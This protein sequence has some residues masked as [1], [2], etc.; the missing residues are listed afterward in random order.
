M[1]KRPQ[2]FTLI[3]LL[4]VIAIIAILAAML[5]PV[6][7]QAKES[8]K[9]AQSISNV[10]QLGLAHLMYNTDY[11]GLFTPVLWDNADSDGP[12]GIDWDASWMRNIF[13]YVRSVQL[14]YSPNAPRQDLPNFNPPNRS[15]GGV[16]YQYAMLPRWQI[17]S[18]SAD[19]GFWE[20]GFGIALID[21]IGGYHHEPGTSYFGGADFCATGVTQAQK[22]SPS[23]SQSAIARVSETALIF[24]ARG[25]EYG[26]FCV[27]LYPAPSDAMPP[28]YGAALEGL[29]FEGRYNRRGTQDFNGIP[30]RMG[31]GTVTFADGSARAL[32]TERFFDIID[33]PAGPAYRYQYSRG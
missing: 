20:T 3:E 30:Y 13:P 26:I 23:L 25:F 24:D 21:G 28:S 5:F 10:K 4:V 8:A 1:K 12:E 9:R 19:P 18:G 22:V 2:G 33:T 31:T 11:D 14:Y 16:L 29:N 7:A 32:T 27:N 6:Y 17:W 15:S